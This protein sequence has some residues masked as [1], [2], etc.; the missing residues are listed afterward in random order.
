MTTLKFKKLLLLTVM[1]TM[2]MLVIGASI[3]AAT[4]QYEYDVLNRL[5]RVVYDGNTSIQYTYDAVGN[6]TQRIVIAQPPPTLTGDFGGANFSPS[7]GYVDVWDL[8][9]FADRWHTRAGEG[10]WDAIFDLAGPNFAGPD[11][12]IDVWDLMT[13]ADHWHEGVKP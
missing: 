9:L 10:N 7:D 12:Y 5:I 2:A 6:R 4:I 8:M 1:A 11:G 3:N 13:L